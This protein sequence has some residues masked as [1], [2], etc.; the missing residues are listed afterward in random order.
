V[1]ILYSYTGSLPFSINCKIFC[2]EK[3][4]KFFEAGEASAKKFHGLPE[5]TPKLN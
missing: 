2:I 5:N 1:V 4:G 3:L